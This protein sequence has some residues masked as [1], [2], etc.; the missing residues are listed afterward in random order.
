MMAMMSNGGIG[1]VLSAVAR[2]IGAHGHEDADALV[3]H[4]LALAVIMGATLFVG[5]IWMGPAIYTKLGG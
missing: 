3:F 4:A 2:A 5:A 1:G